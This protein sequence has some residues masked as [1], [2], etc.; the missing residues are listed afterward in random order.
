MIYKASLCSRCA[1]YWPTNPMIPIKSTIMA[2]TGQW[3]YGHIVKNGHNR[4]LHLAIMA[5]NIGVSYVYGFGT[6]KL[7]TSDERDI[8]K[9]NYGLTMAILRFFGKLWP[10]S[11]YK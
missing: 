3:P 6:Q 5:K 8:K 1:V 11:L 4:I 2:I 9:V 10:I 7:R